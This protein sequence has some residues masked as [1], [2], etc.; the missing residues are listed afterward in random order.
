MKKFLIV[1]ALLMLLSGCAEQ[2]PTKMNIDM[3]DAAGNNLGKIALEEQAKGSELNVDLQGLPPGE[4]AIHFHEVAS[5]KAPDFK[6]AGNHFNPTEKEHG[7]MNAKG[8]HAGDLPNIN[9]DKDG[10][11][12]VKLQSQVT[13]KEERN[14]LLTK[15][16][17]SIVIHKT[18][19]DGMTQPAGNSGERIACGVIKKDK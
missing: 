10:K 1:G 6:S 16:G 17:T 14:S 12:K 18:L 2:N 7:M 15:E 8:S 13:L 11:V 9:V 19:D 5:C 3:F 4:H